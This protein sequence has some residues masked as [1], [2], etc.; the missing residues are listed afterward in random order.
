M[1]R[2][3]TGRASITLGDRTNDV[4]AIEIVS[5]PCLIAGIGQWP[6]HTHAVSVN[7]RAGSID[8]SNRVPAS[9]FWTPTGRSWRKVTP[10][11]GLST[12]TLCTLQR[13]EPGVFSR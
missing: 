2:R 12:I 4:G 8:F 9:G 1:R 7:A 3:Q 13:A 5:R 6:T 10:L 11:K